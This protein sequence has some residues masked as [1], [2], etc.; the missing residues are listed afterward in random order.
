MKYFEEILR[1][2]RITPVLKYITSVTLV[3]VPLFSKHSC[4]PYIEIYDI[5]D[6]KLQKI[7]TD[8]KSHSQ[9]R[10]YTDLGNRDLN[11]IKV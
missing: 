7:Y 1:E 10:K 9:Q 8:K 4:R 2:P 5:K 11:L 6:N 3:G